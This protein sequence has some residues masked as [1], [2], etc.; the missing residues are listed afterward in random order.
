MTAANVIYS[1]AGTDNSTT[2]G[3]TFTVL[4]GSN[5]AALTEEQKKAK[6]KIEFD[7]E[8]KRDK[9]LK[10]AHKFV[11]MNNKD[12]AVFCLEN[13]EYELRYIQIDNP[14]I[15][16]SV[17]LNLA[18]GGA[19]IISAAYDKPTAIQ[20]SRKLYDL[21]QAKVNAGETIINE[22]LFY[23]NMF[24]YCGI[25]FPVAQYNLN[26]NLPQIFDGEIVLS[27]N[28]QRILGTYCEGNRTKA[29]ALCKQ[30]FKEML[31][32]AVMPL[33]QLGADVPDQL[34]LP[35]PQLRLPA[36]KEE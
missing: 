29:T 24:K 3:S 2:S 11:R 33:Q 15:V 1:W 36:P 7:E 9:K 12:M 31:T 28:M 18:V 25:N 5:S 14:T 8:E 35:A 32:M 4:T 17:S 30:I 22:R 13:T 20:I 27:R 23:K 16:Y 10:F 34:C 26:Q 21:M 6:S 19:K